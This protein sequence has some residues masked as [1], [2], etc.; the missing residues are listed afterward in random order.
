MEFNGCTIAVDRMLSANRIDDDLHFTGLDVDLEQQAVVLAI[1][2]E[3]LAVKRNIQSGLDAGILGAH[4]VSHVFQRGTHCGIAGA[5]VHP[6]AITDRRPRIV[7]TALSLTLREVISGFT[8]QD[9]HDAVVFTQTCIGVRNLGS[10]IAGTKCGGIRGLI[11]IGA[12]R[13]RQQHGASRKRCDCSI[14]H[15]MVVDH[16]F[17]NLIFSEKISHRMAYPMKKYQKGLT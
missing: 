5:H 15:F 6:I 13:Y 4:G 17:L 10:G 8:V 9:V 11:S 2:E 14:N 16:I 12:A 7:L 3:Q 1:V